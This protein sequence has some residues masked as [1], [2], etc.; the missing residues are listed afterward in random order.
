M[1]FSKASALPRMLLQPFWS[2]LLI[3]SL[4]S[5]HLEKFKRI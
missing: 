4:A 2:L 3:P 1:L 5:N